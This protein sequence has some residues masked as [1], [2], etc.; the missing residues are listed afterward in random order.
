M[1]DCIFCRIIA[2]ELP[3]DKVYEDEHMFVFKD[4]APK[5]KMHL[6]AV[7]KRHIAQMDDLGPE[8]A[9]LVAHM[10]LKLPEL[11]REQGVNDFRTIINNGAGAGQ[12]VFHLHIHV[13]GGSGLP[14]FG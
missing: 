5:A 2:G 9:E 12:V 6:L 8:H 7:P 10:M 11:A 3:S 4:I 1:S 13:M 14:G